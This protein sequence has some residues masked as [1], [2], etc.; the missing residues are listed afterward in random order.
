MNL[1]ILLPFI[2]LTI[3][4]PFIIINYTFNNCLVW[5][6]KLYEE[7]VD[8]KGIEFKISKTEAIL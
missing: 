3:L 4:L 5:G 8:T 6:L 1:T 7:V 2:N